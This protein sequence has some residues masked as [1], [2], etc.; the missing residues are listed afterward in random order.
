[1]RVDCASWLMN[2]ASSYDW[3]GFFVDDITASEEPPQLPETL[4]PAFHWGMSAARHLPL[5]FFA[6][7]CRNT[8]PQAATSQVAYLPRERPWY[9]SLLKSGSVATRSLLIRSCQY[10]TT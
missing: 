5:V 9:Q 2:F 1:M 7:P 8:G 4:S 6:L 3:I 10:E